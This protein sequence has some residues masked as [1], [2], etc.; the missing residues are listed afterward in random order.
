MKRIFAT[1]L[2]LALLF[3][4]PIMAQTFP[5]PESSTVNDFAGLLS[6]QAETKITAELEALRDETGVVMTVV[7]LS[8]KATFAPDQ[9]TEDF[10]RGLFDQWKIGDAD[11]NDGVLFLVLQADRETRIQLGE[12]YGTDW[13][14][15]TLFVLNRS[16]LPAFREDRFE[17]GIQ[18]GVSDV[19]ASIIRPY[20]AGAAV[21]TA[22]TGASAQTETAPAPASSAGDSTTSGGG[23]GWWIAALFA[24]FAALI[25]WGMLK[26]KLAKCPECGKRGLSVTRTTLREPTETQ[27]GEGERTTSCDKCGHS[28]T[29]AYPIPAL[30]SP[31]GPGGGSSPDMGGGKSGEGGATGKW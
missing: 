10:A 18:D 2:A 22:E 19:I 31:D 4:A 25:G 1:W 21:P 13:Q 30:N 20:L 15:A 23:G 27:P 26:S 24:P 9:S 8:R 3:A 16:I 5:D 29:E 7:T 17:A 6:E 14:L 12:A 28:E 11:R